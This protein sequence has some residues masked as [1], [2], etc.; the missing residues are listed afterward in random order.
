[1]ATAA[2]EVVE[3]VAVVE[4][5]AGAVAVVVVIVVQWSPSKHSTPLNPLRL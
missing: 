4:V 3:I 2:D 5:V 1:M